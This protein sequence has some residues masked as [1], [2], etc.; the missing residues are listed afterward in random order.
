MEYR[1]REGAVGGFTYQRLCFGGTKVV[2]QVCRHGHSDLP[3]RTRVIRQSCILKYGCPHAADFHTDFSPL[4]LA[5]YAS[6][7]L[8]DMHTHT[9]ILNQLSPSSAI[10]R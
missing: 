1:S 5:F 10:C 8:S 6:L 9:Q 3:H 2:L 4:S 7:S